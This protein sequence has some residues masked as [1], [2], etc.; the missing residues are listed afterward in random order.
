MVTKKY[1]GALLSFAA[2]V[3]T[4]WY[5]HFGVP[6]KN[7]GALSKIGLEHHFL[8]WIWGVL[9]F[10][11]LLYNIVFAYKKYTS[12]RLY[13]PLLSVA[14]AGMLL[15]LCFDFDYDKKLQYI[16][17]CAGSLT[18]SVVMG[19]TIF[20]LFVLCYKKSVMFKIFTVITAIILL[21]DLVFLLI[22]KETALIEVLPI[23]AGY[24]L[25]GIVNFREEKIGITR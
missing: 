1:L 5:M 14:G 11:A 7:S 24:L 15:T 22:Y 9:T 25:L 20:L 18:F 6:Y 12:S 23:F 17:H 8:F 2:F 13:I 21:V 16:L 10:A 4:L 19:I 3:Y